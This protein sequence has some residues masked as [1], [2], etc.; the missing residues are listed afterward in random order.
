MPRRQE[1]ERH[2]GKI[3]EKCL[4]CGKERNIRLSLHNTL[5]LAQYISRKQE[6]MKW[7]LKRFVALLER[8]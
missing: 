8:Q 6:N 4:N 1:K 3:Q 7:K 2:K 5:P